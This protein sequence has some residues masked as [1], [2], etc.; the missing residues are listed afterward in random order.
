MKTLETEFTH[1]GYRY[2]QISR[3]GDVAVFSQQWGEKGSTA[4]ETVIV[5]SHNGREIQGVHIPAT[6]FYPSAGQWGQKGWTFTDRDS[7][8]KKAAALTQAR[9]SAILTLPANKNDSCAIPDMRAGATA[10]AW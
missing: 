6:E 9:K 5:Q 8:L 4:Y 7:A 1:K 3:D 2:R 10:S